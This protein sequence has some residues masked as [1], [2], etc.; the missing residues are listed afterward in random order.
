MKLFNINR[1]KSIKTKR[2]QNYLVY[3]IGEII[4]VVVG[5]LV[6]VAINNRNE[7]KKDEAQVDKIAA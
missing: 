6:A 1:F 2:L 4:L 7:A 5:I 3:A